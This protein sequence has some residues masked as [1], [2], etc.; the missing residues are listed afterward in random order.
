MTTGIVLYNIELNGCLNGVFTNDGLSGVI[1]NEIAKIKGGA[2]SHDFSG[3]YDCFYF[4]RPD[5]R[6]DVELE[7]STSNGMY[8]FT[9]RNITT[10]QAIFIGTGFLMNEKQIAV[11]YVSA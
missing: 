2:R 5:L 4:D 1:Y 11:H 7:I 10:R 8:T 9:W 6:N 3:I